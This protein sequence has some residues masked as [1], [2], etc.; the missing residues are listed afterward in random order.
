MQWDTFG[1][2]YFFS[3]GRCR[4]IPQ[5][6]HYFVP[7]FQCVHKCLHNPCTA[8]VQTTH[9]TSISNPSRGGCMENWGVYAKPYVPCPW[10]IKLLLLEQRG[11]WRLDF[12]GQEESKITHNSCTPRFFSC[13]ALSHL[14]VQMSRKQNLVQLYLNLVSASTFIYFISIGTIILVVYFEYVLELLRLEICAANSEPRWAA[15][16]QCA[17]FCLWFCPWNNFLCICDAL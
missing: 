14:C 17:F 3:P 10:I 12:T 6:N 2:L 5:K 13:W 7:L 15:E 11:F 16:I 8:A 1:W 4:V 9:A